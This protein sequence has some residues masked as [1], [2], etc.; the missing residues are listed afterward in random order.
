V[1][2]LDPG[3]QRPALASSSDG[4]R[5]WR[6]HVFTGGVPAVTDLGSIATMYLPTVAAGPD[7]RAYALTYRK[8][9]KLDPYRTTDGGATWRPV[10]GGTLGWVPDPGFVT[11]DGSHVVKTGS[12]FAASHG[13]NKYQP[14]T[15]PGYPADL[16][17][18][19][20]ITW[21]PAAGRYLVFSLSDLYLSE[22]GWTWRQVD[23][24]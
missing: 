10:P 8:D 6:T 18:Q 20:E 1:P 12:T 22:D 13:G 17:R 2:G 11:A 9:Q 23:V 15:L 24:P 16:R 14:V 21:Q 19:T 4:G 7:G 3:T 5:T